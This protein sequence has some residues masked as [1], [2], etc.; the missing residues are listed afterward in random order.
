MNVKYIYEWDISTNETLTREDGGE[1]DVVREWDESTL[2]ERV[3][4][5]V[6]ISK[7]LS[8]L[9]DLLQVHTETQIQRVSSASLDH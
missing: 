9:R 7:L 1:E 6:L 8:V 4:D 3:E 5:T 2:P